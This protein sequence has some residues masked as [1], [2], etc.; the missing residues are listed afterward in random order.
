MGQPTTV[1]L[2]GSPSP[3]LSGAAIVGACVHGLNV[4]TD[5]R[6]A[7]VDASVAWAASQLGSGSRYKDIIGGASRAQLE[8]LVSFSHSHRGEQR[9]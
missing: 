5:A 3:L 9:G 8:Q 6:L 1:L 4:L 2:C 7:G